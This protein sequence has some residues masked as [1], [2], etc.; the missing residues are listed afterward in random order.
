MMRAWVLIG[1]VN[2]LYTFVYWIVN[3]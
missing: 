1:T 3:S 2:E